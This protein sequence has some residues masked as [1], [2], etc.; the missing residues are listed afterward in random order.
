MSQTIR[1]LTD[2]F[3]VAPQLTAEDMS[4]V[5][6]AGFKSVIINRP[7]YEG[8]AEQPV[9]AQVMAA[10]QVAGMVAEYQP[11][12]SGAITQDDVIAFAELIKTLP[13]PILA[14][15]RSGGRCTMLFQAASV[16]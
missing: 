12:T 1:M 3:A 8:G 13:K 11:V 16:L 15:C 14:Y 6:A 10:A 7:D 5:A 4:A 9:S 2:S